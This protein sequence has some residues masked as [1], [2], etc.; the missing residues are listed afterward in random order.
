MVI[1]TKSETTI[2]WAGG[3]PLPFS[4]N[5]GLMHVAT[6]HA[7]LFHLDEPPHDEQNYETADE[8]EGREDSEQDK[9]NGIHNVADEEADERNCGPEDTFV[10]DVLNKEVRTARSRMKRVV[11]C[12]H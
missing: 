7:L 6:H 4:M 3:G 8:N 12:R 5:V 10:R 9:D 2:T 1:I 11:H